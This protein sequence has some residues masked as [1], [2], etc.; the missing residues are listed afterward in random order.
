MTLLKLMEKFKKILGLM[1]LPSEILNSN[2]I[3]ILHIS[4]TPTQIYPALKNF[5]NKLNPE[6]IIHTGDLADDIKLEYNPKEILNYQKEVKPLMEI[7]ETSEAKKVFIVPGN[8]D[9]NEIIN[10]L[11]QKS[12]ILS[13]G[14][15]IKLH[16]KSIG[17]AHKL[18]NLPKNTSFNLYG[19]NLRMSDKPSKTHYLNGITSI[20]IIRLPSGKVTCLSY[21]WGTD[22]NRK[23]VKQ[24]TSI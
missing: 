2:E 22:Y 14:S 20:N 23:L 3:K 5:I 10:Q 7:L 16:N 4:D 12:I 15:I 24:K 17:V 11:S 18:K 21:P 1:Y 19:H 8:H 6:Y 13:E 9:N